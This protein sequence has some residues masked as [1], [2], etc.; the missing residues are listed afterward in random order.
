MLWLL[1]QSERI[2]SL[3]IAVFAQLK[4]NGQIHFE[5]IWWGRHREKE[6]M[7]NSSLLLCCYE[8]RTEKT[9]VKGN[10]WKK[11]LRFVSRMHPILV[12]ISAQIESVWEFEPFTF[13]FS[14]A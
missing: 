8:F 7:K 6:T 2:S 3:L 1:V 10:K 13:V 9:R 5:F 11:I 14:S 12:I 4:Q